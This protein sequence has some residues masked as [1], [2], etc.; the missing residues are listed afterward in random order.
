M[1]LL[2][3]IL[4]P[5]KNVSDCRGSLPA[6]AAVTAAVTDQFHRAFSAVAAVMLHVH[7]VFRYGEAPAVDEIELHGLTLIVH[8]GLQRLARLQAFSVKDVFLPVLDEHGA[9]LHE[10][11]CYIS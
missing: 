10:A 1:T 6:S 2:I 7:P 11:E 5:L 3:S 8:A 4:N 9:C